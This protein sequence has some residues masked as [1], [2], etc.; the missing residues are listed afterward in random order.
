MNCT[1]RL[2]SKKVQ[3][4]FKK[5]WEK[6]MKEVHGRLPD[7]FYRD[8]KRDLW[9]VVR[10]EKNLVTSKTYTMKMNFIKP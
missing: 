2:K 9:I 7:N 6:T 3:Q 5:H 1:K 4:F 10:L 8:F